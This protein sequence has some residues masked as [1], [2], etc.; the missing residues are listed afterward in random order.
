L[1]LASAHGARCLF[2][3]VRVLHPW[4]WCRAAVAGGAGCW[5]VPVGVR[6]DRAQMPSGRDHRRWRFKGAFACGMCLVENTSLPAVGVIP[7]DRT[8]PPDPV[9]CTVL[10]RG[11]DSTPRAT[12]HQPRT[13]SPQWWCRGSMQRNDSRSEAWR[14]LLTPAAACMNPIPLCVRQFSLART[15]AATPTRVQHPHIPQPLPLRRKRTRP[16]RASRT[17]HC[18][19]AADLDPLPRLR[20]RPL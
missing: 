16:H 9:L 20:R 8:P 11:P 10:L 17:A 1:S 7:A 18:A 3:G 14:S 15:P 5:L 6:V 13:K 12:T 2:L 4:C 19:T